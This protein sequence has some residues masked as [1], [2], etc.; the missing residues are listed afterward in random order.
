[1]SIFA[2]VVKAATLAV[3][4]V[5]PWLPAIADEIFR[6]DFDQTDAGWTGNDQVQL[7]VGDGHLQLKAKGNDPYFAS[8]VKGRAGHHRLTL[9]ARFKGNADVQVFWT[10]EASP[11]TSE[12]KS[13]RTELRGS[14]KEFRPVRLWFETDS[15]VT[16]LRIDPF[17]RGGQME[18]DSIVLTDDAPP[19]PQAT[20][21]S[22][23]KLAAGFKAELLYSVP[24]EKMGSWVCMT[25]DPQ[26]RLIVSD[27][28]GKLYRVTPPA[29]GS[30]AT[31]AIEPINVDV[32]M[33]QGLLCAFDSLYVMTNSGD[34]PRVG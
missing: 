31:I 15:P 2:Q 28:Y 8:P 33:A 1:M 32:G 4:F 34:A 18:I 12:D 21:V 29:I 30:D 10:T 23:L 11:A 26:G 19:A 6:W 22:D 5:T 25:A 20:P 14:D 27:Q 3:A 17:S 9:S 13:V 24:A 16:S 7:S